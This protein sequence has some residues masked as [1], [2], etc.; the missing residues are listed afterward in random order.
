MYTILATLK[1][2]PG[3]ELE[4]IEI[5]T[6]LAKEVLSKEERLFDV[7]TACGRE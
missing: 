5:C 2:K 1:A 6:L 7:H 4:V 3:K